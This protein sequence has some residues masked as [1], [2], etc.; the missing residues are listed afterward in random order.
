MKNPHE[1]GPDPNDHGTDPQ[2]PANQRKWP[3]EGFLVTTVDLKAAMSLG[4][5]NILGSL[6][7]MLD[8]FMPTAE[9]RASQDLKRYGFWITP[10][11]DD[12]A[13]AARDRSLEDITVRPKFDF[14]LS[15][16]PAMFYAIT[17]RYW[18]ELPK[19]SGDYTTITLD[20]FDASLVDPNAL[21]I[22]IHGTLITMAGDIL[23]ISPGFDYRQRNQL[24]PVDGRILSFSTSSLDAD[25]SFLNPL[26]DLL[27]A[28]VSGVPNV[29]QMFMDRLPRQILIPHLLLKMALEYREV[30]LSPETGIQINIQQEIVPRKPRIDLTPIHATV[31]AEARSA[32][33][34]VRYAT[35]DLRDPNVHW[36]ADGQIEPDGHKAHITFALPVPRPRL[37]TRPVRL[38]A[39]DADGGTASAEAEVQISTT[40]DPDGSP[41]GPHRFDR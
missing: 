25:P 13:R 22:E 32:R 38:R 40:P 41:Q 15:I 34:E 6:E 1:N 12:E 28:D 21:V 17:Q 29:G 18:H 23:P 14:L 19:K 20:R 39:T 2:V 11:P 31:G 37:V 8:K 35:H 10:S 36:D 4:A 16:T 30:H 33:A 26:K 7:S 9:V 3:P 24:M 5:G 27:G